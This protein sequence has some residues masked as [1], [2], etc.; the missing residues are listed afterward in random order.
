MASAEKA[1]SRRR[2]KCAWY[3][4]GVWE[5]RRHVNTRGCDR[6]GLASQRCSGLPSN[7]IAPSRAGELLGRLLT[8]RFL[9]CTLQ[10]VRV[11]VIV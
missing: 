4:L 8:D 10:A 11:C 7:F 1:M 3:T 5:G 6:V 9:D 2:E